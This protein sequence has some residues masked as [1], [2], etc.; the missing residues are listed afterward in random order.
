MTASLAGARSVVR[1]R[2]SW[3]FLTRKPQAVAPDLPGV[4]TQLIKTLGL[5]RIR[6]R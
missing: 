4:A 2:S 5:I 6:S 3:H 1:E